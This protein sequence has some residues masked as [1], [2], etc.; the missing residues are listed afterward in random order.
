MHFSERS[1]SV[2]KTGQPLT[3]SP[4]QE[5]IETKVCVVG[6]GIAGMSVAYEL[7]RAGREVVVIDD[8]A[9][10]GGE[11]AQTTAHLASALD[12]R[13]GALEQLHGRDGARRAY[14]SHDAAIA[15]IEEI[16]GAE[17]ID[18]DFQRVDGY[19]FLAADDTP[20][21]LERE[22]AAA[23]R[24]G[25]HDAELLP[26]AP[27]SAFDTGPC[28][29]FPR[30]A[31]FHPLRYLAGLAAAITRQG[32]RIFTGTHADRIHGNGRP[33]V[34]TSTG[35]VISADAIVVA[36]NSPV[37]DRVAIHTKQAPY[38]TFVIALEMPPSAM[39][40][41]LYWDTGDPYHY[42]RVHAV[43]AER[44]LL[45]VGGEDHKTAHEDDARER[46][47]RL[48]S[49]TRKRFRMA[50]DVAHRWSGQVLEPADGLAFIGRNP[51]DSERVFI[52]TG[53]SG[54]GMTHGVIAGMLIRDLVLGQHNDWTALYEPS[55]KPIKAI[56]EFAR[57]N[58]SAAGGYGDWLKPGEVSSL[59]DIARGTGAVLQRGA[60]KL[61]VYRDADGTLTACSAICTHLGGIVRWNSAEQSWDCPCH[62]SRFSPQGEVLNGPALHGLKRV[63][64]EQAAST[65]I[66][67]AVA[68]A[69]TA[70]R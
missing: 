43:D 36:T 22:L 53:D 56:K 67:D 3:T 13:F 33:R 7:G 45:I 27:L 60:R 17:Q 55:R 44:A 30:Q 24:A 66:R 37:N 47:S 31:Q 62:G 38:R 23:R 68:A 61:A 70:T 16:V 59:D 46:F 32:G 39:V 8:N 9:I 69:K 15:R 1:T 52:A 5:D 20:D 34:V 18:C 2:W 58:L 42:V 10:G 29:R 14:E 57:I 25:F 4:L 65:R 21:S 64:V 11:T 40:P 6:A 19:L 50:G 35:R 12:D 41:A 48:E 54:N 51:G 28:L 63:D 26:R 49:W